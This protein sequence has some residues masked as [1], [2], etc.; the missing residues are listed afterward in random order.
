MDLTPYVESLR[1]DL[2]AAA[3]AGTDATRETARLLSAA[4]EPAVRL[5]LMD[6]L[7]AMAAEVTAASE[8]GSVEI[9]MHGREPQVVVL[10]EEPTA[11]PPVT[12]SAPPARPESEDEGATARVSLRLPE[13]LKA[14]TE[15]RAAAEGLSLNSWIV[16]A[17]HQAVHGGAH[18]SGQGWSIHGPAGMW[19]GHGPGPR[20]GGRITG[21]GRA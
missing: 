11:E 19:G 17:V 10:G 2:E 13:S 16:R 6:A 8:L 14:Q 15:E 20:R 7:S 3:A 1:A 5:S 4:L 18:W 9:R 12:P 21:F